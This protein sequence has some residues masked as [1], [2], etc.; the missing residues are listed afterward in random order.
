M[1]TRDD[2]LALVRQY[3]TNE[4]L[5]KHCLATESIMGALA[6]RLGQDVEKWR[7]AGLR[8]S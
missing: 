2:A 3:L 1:M 6:E 5:V 7:L 4:N 8:P